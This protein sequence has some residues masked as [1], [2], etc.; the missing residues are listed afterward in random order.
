MSSAAQA[1]LRAFTLLIYYLINMVYNTSNV[2]SIPGTF[3]AVEYSCM[4]L[5]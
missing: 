5:L 4:L 3:K 2:A 1:A